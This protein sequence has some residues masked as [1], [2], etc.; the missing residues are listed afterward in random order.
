MKNRERTRTLVYSA[1]FCA[2]IIAGSYLRIPLPGGVPFTLQ[3]FFV[4]LAGGF[5]GKKGWI[6]SLLFIFMGLAG[7]PVFSSGGGIGY[8]MFPTFGYIAGFLPASFAVGTLYRSK[9]NRLKR[10]AVL[11]LGV[12]VIYL[13]GGIWLYII[14]NY[15]LSIHLSMGNVIKYGML[16]FMPY[17]FVKA[18]VA[19]F[20]LE[21]S[22]KIRDRSF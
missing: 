20:V 15:H 16:A 18:L 12:I 5:M 2:L 3:L 1:L 19:L 14:K 11:L 7:L 21:K 22:M 4:L 13:V 8:V 17:D 6:P 10:L 9:D